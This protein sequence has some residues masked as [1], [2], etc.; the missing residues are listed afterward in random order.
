MKEFLNHSTRDPLDPVIDKECTASG[1]PR[2]PN[3]SGHGPET[4]SPVSARTDLKSSY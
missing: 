3:R 2:T 1:Q 4:R